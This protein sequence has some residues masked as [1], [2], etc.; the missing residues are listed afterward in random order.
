MIVHGRAMQRRVTFARPKSGPVRTVKVNPAVWRLA[1][2]LAGG[3]GHR[4]EVHDSDTVI[5]RNHPSQVIWRVT[6]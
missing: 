6:A 3:N 5:V 1:M 2:R 4:I